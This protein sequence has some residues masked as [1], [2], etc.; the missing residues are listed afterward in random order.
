MKKVV[1]VVIGILVLAAVAAGS[2]FIGY[3]A[4]YGSIDHQTIQSDT[5]T[6]Y[7]QIKEV[8]DTNILV[9]GLAINDINYRGQFYL[10]ISNETIFEWRN[11]KISIDNLDAGDHIS[12]T[13][14]GEV[15]ETAPAQINHVVKIQLLDDEK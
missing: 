5:Q 13:F 3:K 15:Q 11:T 10:N 7:A 9:E 2:Y 6:F 4:G 14:T 8:H 12:I 1:K